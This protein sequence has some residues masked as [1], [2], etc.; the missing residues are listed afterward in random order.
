MKAV[1]I[2]ILLFDEA[3]DDDVEGAISDIKAGDLV[4]D[5]FEVQV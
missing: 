4:Y 3:T 5:A 2:K 1:F